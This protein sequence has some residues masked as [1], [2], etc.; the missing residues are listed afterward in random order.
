[1]DSVFILI[2][3]DPALEFQPFKQKVEREDQHDPER[4]LAEFL[5]HFVHA[6][7]PPD[8][9]YEIFRFGLDLFLQTISEADDFFFRL[10]GPMALGTKIIINRLL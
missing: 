4:K 9:G 3:A 1:M 5:P 6:D 7:S 2:L 10:V 8:P